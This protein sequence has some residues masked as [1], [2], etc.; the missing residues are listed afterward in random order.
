MD[1]SGYTLKQLVEELESAQIRKGREEKEIEEIKRQ[2][3]NQESKVA[4]EQESLLEEAPA[5]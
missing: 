2:I 4:S 5:A 3:Q 1:Y